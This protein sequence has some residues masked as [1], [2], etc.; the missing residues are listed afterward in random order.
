[1]K[2]SIIENEKEI[3]VFLELEKIYFNVLRDLLPDNKFRKFIKKRNN[4]LRNYGL[5]QERYIPDKIKRQV[6]RRDHGACVKCGSKLNI[7]Y[8][9]ILPFS[10][11]GNNELENIQLLCAK[12]NIKKG[13]YI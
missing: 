7:Q 8:D 9:H 5:L 3:N 1:M 11:G 6:F 12:C 10:K 2:Y 4:V 13:D